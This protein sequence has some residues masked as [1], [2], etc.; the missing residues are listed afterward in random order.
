VLV[1]VAAVTR[2]PA[3]PAEATPITVTRAADTTAR[4]TLLI[5]GADIIQQSYAEW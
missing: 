3:G 1:A 4:M 2:A 5:G